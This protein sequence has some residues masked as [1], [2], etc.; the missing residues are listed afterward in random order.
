MTET[1]TDL[2]WEKSSEDKF[3]HMIKSIPL[4]HREIAKQVVEK[5]AVINAKERGAAQVEEPDI[6]QAFFTEVPKAF[7]NLMIRLMDEAEFE[8]KQYEPRP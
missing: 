2:K 7:Y 6:V 4:F 8:Y 5:K 1:K 3:N